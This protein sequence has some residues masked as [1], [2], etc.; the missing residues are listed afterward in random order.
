[1]VPLREHMVPRQGSECGL[2][3]GQEENQ[4]ARSRVD[5]LHRHFFARNRNSLNSLKTSHWH[6]IC[7][8]LFNINLSAKK[9]FLYPFVH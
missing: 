3:T 2:W 5:V 1:M 6:G 8:K 7:K 4:P 9:S